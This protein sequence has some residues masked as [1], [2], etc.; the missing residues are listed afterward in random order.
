MVFKEII[1]EKLTILA[2]EKKSKNEIFRYR[3][4]KNAIQSIKDYDNDINDIKDLDKISGLSKTGSIRKKIIELINTGNISQIQNI[5]N[6]INIIQELSNIYGVG[7]SKAN[8]LVNKYEIKSIEDLKNKYKNDNSILNN[9]QK[10]G[11]DYYEDLLKRIPQKEMIK[12]EDFIIK[13][14]KNIDINNDLIYEI[15]GSY[16]R[17]AI[18]SGDI[19]VLCSTKNNNTELFNKI[20]EDLESEK[21]IQE[22]LAKG[23]KKFMG[24][25]KLP[26]YR[27]SR[28][29]DM[30]YTKKEYYPFALL[31]FTGSGQ[32]NVD[33]RNHAI[34]L[35]YSLSEY[36]LKK[37]GEFIDNNGKLFETE[38]DIFKFLGIKY[39][40]P[41]DRKAGI[42]E[43]NLF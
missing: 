19:D 39:I 23:D 11:L 4:Y 41:E 12:H 42:L 24:I 13:F 8:E 33:M 27:S 3:A 17:G 7:P 5:G 15:T 16:R 30:I 26:R 21:Y 2:D 20:I 32:F 36:G 37:N 35:G 31:Y 29:L 14:I 28:R 10:I 6:E 22:T 18:D 9:K 43:D 34:T 40:K 38:E 25:C 1:L